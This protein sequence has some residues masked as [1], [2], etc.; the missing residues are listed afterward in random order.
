LIEKSLCDTCDE[1]CENRRIINDMGIQ[2]GTI[3]MVT[4]CKGYR[5]CKTAPKAKE[6]KN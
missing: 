1:E 3:A 4:Q 5:D 2:D 6:E